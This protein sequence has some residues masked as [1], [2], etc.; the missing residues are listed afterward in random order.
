MLLIESAKAEDKAQNYP[1]AFLL[2]K[3][4]IEIFVRVLQDDLNQTVRTSISKTVK[5]HMS[6]AEKLKE[7]LERTGELPPPDPELERFDAEAMPSIK[8]PPSQ[9]P[10]VEDRE[11]YD[12]RVGTVVK[13]SSTKFWNDSSP[14]F[15]RGANIL[16]AAC[17][18]ACFQGV[19]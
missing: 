9:D 5:E 14:L 3:K 18:R 12:I 15:V 2:Y 17:D 13:E 11:D 16:S 1:R 6:R 8:M 4:A 19:Y 10:V 7:Y